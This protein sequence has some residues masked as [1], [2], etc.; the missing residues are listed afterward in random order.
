MGK[1]L[2]RFG[3][4]AFPHFF[5]AFGEEIAG[6]A[7]F[8]ANFARPFRIKRGKVPGFM[9]QRNLP[10]RFSLIGTKK[11]NCYAFDFVGSDSAFPFGFLREGKGKHPA[12]VE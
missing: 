5:I 10:H 6:Q 12:S 7:V 3:L 4:P 2:E 9:T 1:S 11:T 8:F